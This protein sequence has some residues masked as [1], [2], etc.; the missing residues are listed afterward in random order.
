MVHLRMFF[1]CNRTDGK[2]E[3]SAGINQQFHY[4]T[5]I[6]AFNSVA[7]STVLYRVLNVKCLDISQNWLQCV[8]HEKQ[9][10]FDFHQSIRIYTPW[11]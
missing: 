10:K 8:N 1:S 5:V 7:V 9:N 11:K 2:C 6:N 4:V 3:M